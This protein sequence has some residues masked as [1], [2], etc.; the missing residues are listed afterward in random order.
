[1]KLEQNAQIT[2]AQG[3]LTGASS[4]VYKYLNF[5]QVKDYTDLA[6]SVS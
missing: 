5:D 2:D 4:T 3:T 6:A 1:M